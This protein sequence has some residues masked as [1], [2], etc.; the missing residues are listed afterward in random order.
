MEL[1]EIRAFIAAV[2]EG[3]PT[4]AARRLHISQPS[5]SQTVAGLE[6][7]PGMRLVHVTSHATR[8]AT[9]RSQF[10]FALV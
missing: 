8:T 2:E 5:V 1:R 3:G 6:R 4:P 10:L 7:E 9:G